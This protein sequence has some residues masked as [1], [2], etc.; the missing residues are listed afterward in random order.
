[1]IIRPCTACWTLGGMPISTMPFDS[2]ATISTPTSGLQ[3]A[4]FAAR[5]RRAADHDG[6]HG[7]EQPPLADLSVAEAELRGASTPPSA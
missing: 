5:Q 7:G 1:M 3:H 4:A 2:T 6:R